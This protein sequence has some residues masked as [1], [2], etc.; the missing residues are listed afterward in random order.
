M[1]DS[2]LRSGRKSSC[3]CGHSSESFHNMYI[4]L[5]WHKQYESDY[6]PEIAPELTDLDLELRELELYKYYRAEKFNIIKETKNTRDSKGHFIKPVSRV[7]VFRVP[8][9]E[10]E[11]IIKNQK[12]NK[13]VKFK[14]IKE[15]N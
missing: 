6:I 10:A 5:D 15:E 8:K 7:V 9:E 3:G 1:A 4:G 13:N 2:M 12:E 11:I 14:L